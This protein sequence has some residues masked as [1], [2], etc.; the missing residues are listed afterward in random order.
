MKFEKE[1]K[2]KENNVLKGNKAKGS[3]VTKA[4]DKTKKAEKSPNQLQ[5]LQN[6]SKSLQA[7]AETLA[8]ISVNPS[9][10]TGL[11][12]APKDLYYDQPW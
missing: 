12:A 11:E 10:P 6:I 5:K 8:S 7:N 4:S 1:C 3:N 2:D 9:A